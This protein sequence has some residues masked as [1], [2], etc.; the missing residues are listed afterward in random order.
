MFKKSVILFLFRLM[1][2]ISTSCTIVEL[3]FRHAHTEEERNEDGDKGLIPVVFMQ[4]T[5]LP[6]KVHAF[7]VYL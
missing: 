5:F 1:L 6:K 7:S 2:V 4:I 3:G